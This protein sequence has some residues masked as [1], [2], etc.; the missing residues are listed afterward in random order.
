MENITNIKAESRKEVGKQI[1]RQLRKQGKIPAIIYGGK[2]ESI[3]ISILLNDVRGILK[4]D[5]GEN[6]VLKIRRDDIEVDAMLKE[7]QYDYLSDN[8]IHVDFIRIDLNKAVNVSVPVTVHGDPIGV[9]VEDGVFDF[10]T[11]EIEIRCL[12]TKIPK[13]YIVDTSQLHAGHSIKTEDLDLG[14]D[15]R[16]MSDPHRVICA[17]LTKV[18][19]EEVIEEEA[20]E[21]EGIEAPKA[22]AKPEEAEQKPGG[23]KE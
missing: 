5:K 11:R 17:V 23:E 10:I 21:E 4:A 2:K 3:P 16:L 18:K 8:I 1:A 22:E 19:K 12:P 13:E 14:E 6:T 20:V 7:V 9:K 15:I